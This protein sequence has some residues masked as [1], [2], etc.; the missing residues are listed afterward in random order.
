[1]RNARTSSLTRGPSRTWLRDCTSMILRQGYD[2]RRTFRKLLAAMARGV[3]KC[4]HAA[5][6]RSGS[7]LATEL[8]AD[9][10]RIA[11]VPLSRPRTGVW[12]VVGP[13]AGA[14]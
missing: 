13:C 14:V 11:I 9:V 1:M 2:D 10:V 5:W 6:R 8:L 4:V 7:R 3:R 12:L